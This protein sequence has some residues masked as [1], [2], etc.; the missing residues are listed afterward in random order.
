MRRREGATH[1]FRLAGGGIAHPT[2]RALLTAVSTTLMLLALPS[3][4][5]GASSAAKAQLTGTFSV[6]IRGTAPKA[7]HGAHYQ[8]NWSFTPECDAGACAVQ[9]DTL[10]SSCV[11]GSCPQPPSEF[12]FAG[13][14]L[15]FSHGAYLGSFSVKTGCTVNG[16][17]WPYAYQQHT[18]LTLS[19]TAAAT[20]GSIGSTPLRNVSALTGHLSLRA[21]ST[22]TRGCGTYTQSFSLHGKVAR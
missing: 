18:T 17:Y 2:R 16:N 4:P 12:S 7:V 5:A 6:S 14:Q 3:G 21:V 13:D 8:I 1:A 9:V 22:G 15:A 20:V 10:A 19:P 11:S